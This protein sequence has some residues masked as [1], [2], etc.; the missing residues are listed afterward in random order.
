MRRV[1]EQSPAR[2]KDCTPLDLDAETNGPFAPGQRSDHRPLPVTEVIEADSPCRYA[3]P[4]ASGV[5]CGMRAWVVERLG[6]PRDVL[7]LVELGTPTPGLG[8]LRLHVRAA[9]LGLPDVRLCRGSY[10]FRPTLPFVPGQEVCGVVDAVGADVEVP[11]GTRLMAVTNFFDGRGGFADE[12]IARAESAF[13][14][15]DTMED[16]DAACFRIGYSTAWIGLVRRGGLRLG[17]WLLVLGAAGGSGLAAVRLGRAL[18]ARVIAAVSGE[19]KCDLC[20]RAG[21]EAVIDRAT[22]PVVEAVARITRG[23]GVAIV[24]DPVG[25]A[26][27]GAAVECLAPGGR[28]LAVGFASGSWV[29]ADI[30][31]L[32]RRNASVVG[33]YAGGVARADLDADHEALLALSAH[34]ELGGATEVVAFDALPDALDAIDRA[35]ALGKLV[36]E[37]AGSA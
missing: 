36:V 28:L 20:A 30:G 12:T 2:F 4:A 37:V 1:G 25:G 13:R 26:A 9:G 32:V 7:R 10:P 11:L 3:P 24:Y 14:V 8:E 35:Q 22:E 21:A 16:V 19:A 31:R 23:T 27:A 15:P 5:E 29:E 18:G 34:G 33:V 17:D 6:A